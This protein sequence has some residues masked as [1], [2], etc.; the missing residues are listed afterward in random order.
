MAGQV[1]SDVGWG[2]AM[3]GDV[4]YYEASVGRGDPAAHT[5]IGIGPLDDVGAARYLGI[6]T[7]SLGTASQFEA[8]VLAL[9]TLT[10]GPFPGVSAAS[11]WATL[12]ALVRARA[13]ACCAMKARRVS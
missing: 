4:P 13:Q 1:E 9:P 5:G 3:F 8:A 10:D 6:L 11:W 12:P 7:A 2:P